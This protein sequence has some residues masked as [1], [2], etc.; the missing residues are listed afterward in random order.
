MHALQVV[1]VFYHKIL[2]FHQLYTLTFH[3]MV[4]GEIKNTLC[5]SKFISIRILNSSGSNTLIGFSFIKSRLSLSC[6]DIMILASV[7][8]DT[9]IHSIIGFDKG[10]TSKGVAF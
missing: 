3:H 7:V 9:R 6:S 10:L 8:T 1:V 5:H 2:D 4:Y